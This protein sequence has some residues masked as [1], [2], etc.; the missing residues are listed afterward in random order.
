MRYVWLALVLALAAGCVHRSRS[1]PH[2][3]ELRG[4]V[5]AATDVTV[6]VRHKTGQRVDVAIDGQTTFKRSKPFASPSA[7]LPGTRV[8]I[9]VESGEHGTF[10][11]RQIWIP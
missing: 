1:S 4:S 11:A 5:I 10:R 7:L 9:T 8:I 2:V 6:R 3:W